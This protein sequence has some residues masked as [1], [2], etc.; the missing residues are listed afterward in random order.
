MNELTFAKIDQTVL[1]TLKPPDRSYWLT[2]G[3]L[4]AGALAGAACWI[5]QILTGIGVAGLNTALDVE[6]SDEAGAH[7]WP[8]PYQ[9]LD[10]ELVRKRGHSY[11]YQGGCM[12]G[13]SGGLL[14]VT[15][16]P[17]TCKGCDICV[18][19]CPDDALRTIRQTDEV[20]DDLR[21]HWV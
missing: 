7:S 1:D 2:V 8:W 10:V 3:I 6:A 21:S 20:V 9:E 15:I 18:A 13:A 12:Y 17:E 14:S 4:F 11:Y 5:Y 16:N 19:V